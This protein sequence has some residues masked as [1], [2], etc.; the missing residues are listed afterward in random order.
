M[1]LLSQL[2]AHTD[3]YRYHR[4]FVKLGVAEPLLPEQTSLNLA[5]GGVGKGL[6][7]VPF[8]LNYLSSGKI[9]LSWVA[10]LNGTP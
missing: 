7:S 10:G 8:R 2:Q 5:F 3:D 4:T 6:R 9:P 1:A